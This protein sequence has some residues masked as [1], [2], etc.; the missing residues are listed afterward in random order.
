MTKPEF[1]KEEIEKILEFCNKKAQIFSIDLFKSHKK[2]F[3]TKDYNEEKFIKISYL[4]FISILLG[5]LHHTVKY[6]SNEE[7]A[8]KL[9]S[10]VHSQIYSMFI[11]I[12]DHFSMDQDISTNES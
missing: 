1:Y 9:V 10:Q 12:K 2:I 4:F 8:D 6:V 3:Q 11:S 7:K 5:K